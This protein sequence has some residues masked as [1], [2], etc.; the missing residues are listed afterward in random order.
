MK[1]GFS[2][3]REALFYY[4]LVGES[5]T[6][7]FPESRLFVENFNLIVKQLAEVRRKN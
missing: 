7:A 1:K 6:S 4:L 2:Y 3:Q 5:H